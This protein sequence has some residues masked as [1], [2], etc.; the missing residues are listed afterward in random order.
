M[1]RKVYQINEFPNSRYKFDIIDNARDG[2]N[3]VD[4]WKTIF[5]RE[6][7]KG[8]VGIINLGYFGLSGGEYASGCKIHGEWLCKQ[9]YDAYG[10]CIDKEG[11]AFVGTGKE[12]NAYSYAEAVPT[13]LYNGTESNRDQTWDRNGTTTLGFKD[14][15][16]VCMLCDK[17][18]G[19]SSAEQIEAMEEYGCQTILRMDGSW[20]SHGV[21]GYGKVVQPSQMRNDR[22]YLII[23]DKEYEV[24]MSDKKLFL[25][26][27]GTGSEEETFAIC[28]EIKYALET[29]EGVEVMISRYRDNPSLDASLR[30]DQANKWGANLVYSINVNA[31]SDSAD[32]IT[33]AWTNKSTSNAY[34]FA[35]QILE[36][37]KDAG[38]KTASAPTVLESD[39]ILKETSACAALALFVGDYSTEYKRFKAVEISVKA[40]C[41]QLGIAYYDIP[42][43]EADPVEPPR[44]DYED[45]P[46]DQFPDEET[47]ERFQDM[48]KLGIFPENAKLGEVIRYGD[49]VNILDKVV[50]N[51]PEEDEDTET[52]IKD[53]IEGNDE[54]ILTIDEEYLKNLITGILTQNG[55]TKEDMATQ[56][57]KAVT[58]YMASYNLNQKIIDMTKTCF[59]V[60]IKALDRVDLTKI[61]NPS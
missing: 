10:I 11:N 14:G 50:E 21:L 30:A 3:C 52:D 8:A 20:S 7:S 55:L 36:K 49:L 23:Y 26:P 39:P 40:I 1:A 19:Q 59:E 37:M 16:L 56:V 45:D 22:S 18:N 60:V 32:G 47:R 28:D 51:M 5:E 58:E 44:S 2:K 41:E 31:T 43:P 53:P 42:S 35:C 61:N 27:Y 54:P 13:F 38:L 6:K 29:Y 4:T 17:D 15:N 48:K 57:S 12:E 24:P 9:V 46:Y 33:V 34:K 25:D